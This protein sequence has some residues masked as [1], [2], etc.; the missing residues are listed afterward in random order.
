MYS[1][2]VLKAKD[3]VSE[4]LAPLKE[5]GYEF[6]NLDHTL[7]VF[8]RAT[9]L[10]LKEWL[11]EEMLEMLQLAALFHDTGFIKQYDNNEEIW[12]QIAEEW[13]KSQNYPQDKIEIV[14]RII[15]ATIP[16]FNSP[17]S[18]AC[19]IIKDADLDNLWRKDCFENTKKLKQEILNIK[20]DCLEEC[21][22]CNNVKDFILNHSFYTKTQQEERGKQL[23]ENKKL[24][25]EKINDLKKTEG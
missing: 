6:H 25:K 18:I 15:L 21:S 23:E 11:D 14:K 17:E 3:Y 12:A 19:K 1:E 16:F 2:I 20:W 10:W 24:L 9:Y 7:D 4:L 13:L 22:W 8:E 5:K